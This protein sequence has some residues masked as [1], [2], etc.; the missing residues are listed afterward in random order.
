MK[1]YNEKQMKL[2]RNIC[3]KEIC[4]RAATAEIK[5]VSLQEESYSSEAVACVSVSGVQRWKMIALFRV[6]IAEL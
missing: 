5:L 3:N 1:F 4:S 2:F 6:D